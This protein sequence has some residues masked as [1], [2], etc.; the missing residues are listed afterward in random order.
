[1]RLGGKWTSIDP[2]FRSRRR[3][4]V[5]VLTYPYGYDQSLQEQKIHIITLQANGIKQVSRRG[6]LTIASN[7]QFSWWDTV[8]GLPFILQQ[9]GLIFQNRVRSCFL[10]H[11]LPQFRSVL[12]TTSIVLAP[13]C[14][15]ASAAHPHTSRLVRSAAVVKIISGFVQF[16]NV[17]FADLLTD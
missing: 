5:L 14:S 15:I 1:M 10:L 3:D 8:Y 4:F 12:L 13:A 6:I 9:R 2:K 11:P 7:Q 16:R 17:L